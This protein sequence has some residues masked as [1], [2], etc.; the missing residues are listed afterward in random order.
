MVYADKYFSDPRAQHSNSL[1]V[2]LTRDSQRDTT[3]VDPQYLETV[4]IHDRGYQK[5][6]IDNSIH[7]VPVDEVGY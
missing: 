1:T 4:T 5:Y 2:R 3:D 6:S 7:L